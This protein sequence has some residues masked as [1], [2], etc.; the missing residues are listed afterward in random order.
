MA[1]RLT[2]AVSH[3]SASTR[4][5][6][7]SLNRP[8][9]G[10]ADRDRGGAPPGARARGAGR[11]RA[12]GARRGARAGARRAGEQRRRGARLRQLGDGRLRG[13]RRRYRGGNERP[14]R[15]SDRRRRVAGRPPGAV[16][17]G[18]GEAIVISTG[19]A[20]PAGADAVVRV[21]DT[22]AGERA[23]EI[24]VEVEPQSNLRRAGEDIAAGETVLRAGAQLGPA[25]LG[26]IASVGRGEVVCSRRPR[27]SLLSTGDELQEPGEPLRP[28]AIRNS[29]A[30]SLAALVE[31]SGAEVV[32]AEIVRDDREATVEAL[33]RALAGDVIVV[34]GGVSVG[35]H[36]H[37]RPALA[38]LGAEQVFW[39]VS[40]RPGKPTWFGIHARNLVFGL[41]GNPVSSMVTFVLFAR[42]AIRA[43][44]GAG[45]ARR[46]T[47]AILDAEYPKRPGRAHLVRCRLELRDDGWHARPTKEQGSHVLTS[48]LGADALAI[49]P[50]ARGDVGAGERVEIELLY[51]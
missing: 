38:E 43:M 2:A 20:L 35:E 51:A 46:R 17:L 50:A 9:D 16:G 13:S 3:R 10:R 21:E 15:P 11:G 42:P 12:G 28:G 24:R 18:P 32:A 7:I 14:A 5:Q 25:E 1:E 22:A 34:S 33:G 40:L 45:D 30:H 36:D 29:N 23:V 19:A 37:I 47:T 49:V 39:G 6:P 44:L 31:R 8:D 4:V 48:M 27:V 26:V 41:P